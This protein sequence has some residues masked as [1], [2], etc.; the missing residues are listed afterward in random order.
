MVTIKSDKI[1]KFLYKFHSLNNFSYSSL[2]CRQVYFS[3]LTE[4]NDP[5]EMF[6]ST[7]SYPAGTFDLNSLLDA[8]RIVAVEAPEQF[9]GREFSEIEAHFRSSP[10]AV[11]EMLQQIFSGSSLLDIARNKLKDHGF[12]CLSGDLQNVLSNILMWSHYTSNFKGYV[13]K[14]DTFKLIKSLEMLN[15][16]NKFAFMPV[17]YLDAPHA[18]TPSSNLIQ[19]SANAVVSIQKKHRLWDYEN[20]YRFISDEKGLYN[21]ASDALDSIYI[22]HSLSVAE[23][24]SLVEITKSFYPQAQKYITTL[25]RTAYEVIP[26]SIP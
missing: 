8:M 25:S 17:D 10:D 16:S 21:F 9:G 15:T 13:L 11:E 14:F 24:N 1:P 23:K 12:Y 3:K 5:F 19:T 4:L 6:F 7:S 18:V 20:E 22:G 2:I 26:E